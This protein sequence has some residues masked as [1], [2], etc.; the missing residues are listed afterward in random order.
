MT[1]S[2]SLS[3]SLSPLPS[4]R[5][6]DESG[7]FMMEKN[8]FV[9][10]AVVMALITDTHPGRSMAY[11][12]D[13]ALAADDLDFAGWQLPVTQTARP[14]TAEGPPHVIDAIVRR[15]AP[16][17]IAESGIGIPHS[18]THRWW[19]PG[20]AGVLSTMLFTLLLLTLSSRPAASSGPMLQPTAATAHQPML[21]APADAA[22]TP[23]ELTVASAGQF[24][25]STPEPMTGED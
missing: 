17:L 12:E 23:A 8:G 9:D 20:L 14:R 18:G 2:L 7:T 15:A 3:L 24:P 4:T 13:L 11:P 25:P 21:P 5:P 1:N 16:P 22:E 19:L 6:S 10:E